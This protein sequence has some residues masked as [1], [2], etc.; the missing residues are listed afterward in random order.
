MGWYASH[1][2]QNRTLQKKSL[3]LRSAQSFVILSMMF[4]RGIG[5]WNIDS[6]IRNDAGA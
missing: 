4:G 3:A 6:D 5:Q 2:K 1:E